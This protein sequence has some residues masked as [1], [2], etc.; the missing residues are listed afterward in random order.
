MTVRFNTLSWTRL[1]PQS[2]KVKTLHKT[3]MARHRG[4]M[5]EKKKK[6]NNTLWHS[7]TPLCFSGASNL[8]L[9]ES[10]SIDSEEVKL[11]RSTQKYSYHFQRQLLWTNEE[12]QPFRRR[13]TSG[14]QDVHG[15]FCLVRTY[16]YIDPGETVKIKK[17]SVK[18]P[19]EPE[20]DKRQRVR[21]NLISGNKQ[22]TMKILQ[23]IM[24]KTIDPMDGC[25]LI[26][27]YWPLRVD[28]GSSSERCNK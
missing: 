25:S 13:N 28:P 26:L 27:W 9:I 22:S 5:K 6:T 8:T 14:Q 1:W 19:L 12:W 4:I 3:K 10:K 23:S 20:E 15:V 18:N 21:N 11:R 16:I 7:V 24:K 2:S 17:K